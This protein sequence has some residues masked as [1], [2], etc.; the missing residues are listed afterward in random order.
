MASDLP[1]G[2]EIIQAP[3]HSVPPPAQSAPAAS[4][5]APAEQPAAPAASPEADTTALPPGFEV[6]NPEGP[7]AVP[8]DRPAPESLSWSEVGRQAIHNTP[9]SALQLGKDIL[10]PVFSPVETAKGIK[11]IVMGTMHKLTPGVQPDEAYADA[12]VD[13][14]KNRYGGMD[15]LKQT[16]AKDPVGFLNDL[17]TVLTLGGKA[18]ATAPGKLG[19]IGTA[20]KTVGKVIN[21]VNIAMKAAT[22][23]TRPIG[24]ATSKLVGELGTHTGS[25]TLTGAYRAGKEG[26]ET[27]RIF[28]RNMRG[29]ALASEVTDD[30]QAAIMRM[31]KAKNA[32]YKSGMIDIKNDKTKLNFD[33]IDDSIK[34]A[35]KNYAVYYG[36][37][38]SPAAR[39]ALADVKVQ[40]ESWKN[41]FPR[42]FH[43]PE[44]LDRLKVAVGEILDKQTPGSKARSAVNEVYNS[45]RKTINDQAPGYAKVMKSYEDAA[46]QIKEIERTLSLNPQ[47]TIDTQL[48]KLQSIIRNNANTNYGRRAELG[49]LL[50]D[51][52]AEHLI[53]RLQGQSLTSWKPRGLGAVTAS[54]AGLA[55]FANPA[56]WAGLPFTSPRLMGEAALAAGSASRNAPAVSQGL[57]QAGRLN[58]AIGESDQDRKNAYINA[59]SQ[60][61]DHLPIPGKQ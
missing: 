20:T 4:P 52:G 58:R 29:E 7:P 37:T 33:A 55:G 39:E 34:S 35:Q 16:I 57:S 18:L 2:F 42:I 10:S 60:A 43:T 45:I 15:E 48:R 36:K 17:S 59:L 12:V 32:A 31:R 26:G 51:N 13:F 61:V 3:D 28:A 49:Q 38:V 41:A 11:N 53:H 27:K 19:A 25:D 5:V 44:G 14:Y 8:T 47:A 46:K 1:P 21:P 56:F 22:P 9:S 6:V 50:I 24:W 23:I 54:G 40:V 30:A